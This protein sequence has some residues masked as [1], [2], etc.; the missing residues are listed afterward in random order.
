MK[1]FTMILLAIIALVTTA[2]AQWVLQTN[3]LG[4][5]DAAAVGKIQFVSATEGWINACKTGALLHTVNGGNT[6]DIVTPYLTE[7]SGSMSDPAVG[8]SWTD[9]SHGW[10]MKTLGSSCATAFDEINSNGGLLYSTNNGGDS[11]GRYAFPTTFLTTTYIPADLMGTWQLQQLT[12]N[13]N[14]TSSESSWQYGTISIDATGA[15]AYSLTKN[16][17]QVETGSVPLAVSSCGI[18][19]VTGEDDF[20]GFMSNDKQSIIVTMN[21]GDGRSMMI[22][23]KVNITT[24]YATADLIGTWQM[25]SITVPNGSNANSNADWTHGSFTISASGAGVGTSVSSGGNSS[26][27]NAT[28]VITSTGIVTVNGI[29]IH[30]F[31]SADKQTI[32]FVMTEDG[33]YSLIALQ[34][35]NTSIS[36]TSADL[37]GKWQMHALITSSESMISM[38]G[39]SLSSSLGAWAK[40]VYSV[41]IMDNSISNIVVNGTEQDK[42]DFTLNIST[43]GVITA[44]GY[45]D[46][47]MS[48]DKQTIYLTKTIIENGITGYQLM[49]LQRDKTTSGDMGLQ[50]QFADNNN[51]WASVFNIYNGSGQLF[52][53]TNGGASW[54]QVPQSMLGFFHFVDAS[55]GWMVSSSSSVDN[56]NTIYHTTDGGVTWTQQFT[57]A[58]RNG[59]DVSFNTIYFSDLTHG[60]AVG[61]CGNVLKT[62][63][64]GSTWTWVTTTGMSISSN[65]KCVF[66]L[67]AN[68][69]WIASNEESSDGSETDFLLAT[70]DGGATWIAQPIPAASSILSLSFVDANHGWFTSDY[71][72]IAKFTQSSLNIT[73]GGLSAALTTAEKNSA[74]GLAISGIMDARDF[75]SLRDEMPLLSYLDLSAVSVEAY[76]GSEGTYDNTTSI[77]YPANTIPQMAFFDAK[78]KTAKNNLTTFIFP[79]SVTTIDTYA[80]C[81]SGLTSINIPSSVSTIGYA[82]FQKCTSLNTFALPK[83]VAYIGNSA[84]SFNN[85]NSFSIAS[86]NSNYSVIDDVLYNKAG[87]H[88]V[89]FPNAKT[90]NF[91]I[92]LGVVVVDT[93]AFEGA[94]NLNSVTIPASVTNIEG[95]AFYNCSNLYNIHVSASTPIDL[96]ASDNVF[97]LVDK[98]NSALYVPAGSKDLYQAAVQWKAFANII[99][100]N[101]MITYSVTVPVGTNE[102]YIAGDMNNWNFY[103]MNKVDD[104]HYTITL[105]SLTSDRYKYCSA[106]DWAYVEVNADG[107]YLPNRSYTAS[108]IVARWIAGTDISTIDADE[109]TLYPNPATDGFYINTGEGSASVSIYD[110]NG[111]LMLTKQILDNEFVNISTF[112]QGVYIIKIQTKSGNIV[113]KL[114]KK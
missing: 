79:A 56:I 71:G 6:W 103:Q 76:S 95:F 22:L 14:N 53:S 62:I 100:E 67:N 54:S 74:T 58:T 113:K 83:T 81:G 38:P 101:Q 1:K 37:T 24:T 52:R 23:H 59:E 16:S 84:F 63:D 45:A 39:S 78:T 89:A 70:K 60:W 33:G 2:N 21:G 31:M 29:D 8:M 7:V 96:A 97:W 86:D 87:T 73:A 48:A 64:G 40:G 105:S 13:D 108:D 49:V 9:A 17:G 93:A 26:S 27:N 3:P 61:R 15:G 90:M 72:Q 68:T 32:T 92:P 50:V 20:S 4:S 111:T 102:C 18:V 98:N 82:A 42:Q 10:A 69:G 11:W 5:G 47:F 65:S 66:F 34:K 30:G 28:F 19:S 80:F 91:D 46:G 104:T 41:S 35:I 110:L 106:A 112:K 88:L 114:V 94:T 36:Y 55:N 75:K 109:L 99:E 85:L 57:Q 44:N 77:T 25:H 12:T 107:S 51:G 43:S